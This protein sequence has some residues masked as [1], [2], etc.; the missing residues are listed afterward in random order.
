MDNQLVNLVVSPVAS[1]VV[2]QVSD[3]QSNRLCSRPGSQRPSHQF[4]L[5]RNLPLCL[6]DSQLVHLVVSPVAIPVA[7][8]VA[9]QVGNRL[10]SLHVSLASVLVANR[11]NNLHVN[12]ASNHRHFQLGDRPASPYPGQPHSRVNNRQWGLV[13]NQLGSQHLIQ[14]CDRAHSR[15]LVQ[16]DNPV[17]SLVLS[18]A[19]VLVDNRL[20]SQVITRVVSRADSQQV[21]QAANRVAVPQ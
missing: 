19:F 11:V 16:V 1:P 9:S 4:S 17:D 5:V 18:L 21:T 20:D 7:S 6:V 10:G 2:S 12:Q 8:P 15:L 14:A 13:G 3:L